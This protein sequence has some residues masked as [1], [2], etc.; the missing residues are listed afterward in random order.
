MTHILQ[1]QNS[2]IELILEA[3]IKIRYRGQAV[4]LN[5]STLES[6]QENGSLLFKAI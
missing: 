5:I 2:V 6:N 4:A 1:I 3:C